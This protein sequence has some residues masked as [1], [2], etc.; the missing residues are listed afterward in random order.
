MNSPSGT[1]CDAALHARHQY[2]LYLMKNQPET[3]A[4]RFAKCLVGD[5]VISAV[6]YAELE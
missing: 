5:V 6:T 3:V 1:P 4:R 2:V